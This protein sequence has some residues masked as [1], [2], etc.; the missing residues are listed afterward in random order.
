MSNQSLTIGDYFKGG[1]YAG[2][3]KVMDTVYH[4]IIAP[5]AKG[6]SA[7]MI[8]KTQSKSKNTSSKIDGYENTRWM[9]LNNSP[10]PAAEYCT[11]LDI[12]GYKDWYLPS[13]Y[14][15]EIIFSAFK[16]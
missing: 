6:E 12:D 5:K 2:D 4:L 15:L 3:I 8:S 14:E 1:Y 13:I 11:N 9:V 16:P 7:K 10:H